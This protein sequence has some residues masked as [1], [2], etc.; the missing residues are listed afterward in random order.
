MPSVQIH[1]PALIQSPAYKCSLSTNVCLYLQRK[2]DE[3][4]SQIEFIVSGKHSFL[5]Y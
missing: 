3:L 2:L 4:F 1:I 5:Y